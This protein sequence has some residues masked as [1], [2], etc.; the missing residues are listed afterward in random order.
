[1]IKMKKFNSIILLAILVVTFIVGCGNNDESDTDT[2]KD[3]EEKLY[4]IGGNE[5]IFDSEN[6]FWDSEIGCGVMFPEFIKE[7]RN[8]NKVGITV[9]GPDGMTFEYGSQ[10]Y[11][12][13][14][15]SLEGLSEDEI[16]EKLKEI[17]KYKVDF[18]GI[19]KDGGVTGYTTADI[20]KGFTNVD[21]I[22][23]VDG[24][25]YYFAYNDKF[26]E[27]ILTEE[28]RKEVNKIVA[29]MDNLKNNICLFGDKLKKQQEQKRIAVAF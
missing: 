19:F 21:E 6:A 4:T 13:F 3:R 29:E 20:K 18:F 14:L 23:E 25:K 5:F 1:M 12:Q 2:S 24:Y 9:L 8:D 28:E 11:M 27:V 26:D 10:A 16:E 15:Q 22:G 7:L 17:N